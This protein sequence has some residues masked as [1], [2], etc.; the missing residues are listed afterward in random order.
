MNIIKSYDFFHYLRRL[1]FVEAIYLYGSR[2]KNSA[3]SSSDLD[4]AILCPKASVADWNKVN[5]II[6][7]ADTLLKID[8][9]RLDTL[10]DEMLK[11]EIEKD[12][13]VLFERKANNYS[14]YE[15]FLDLGEAIEKFEDIMNV[16]IKEFT[17]T[18]EAAIHIFEYSFESF[19]NCLKKIAVDEGLISPSPRS[20][21]Q[22]AFA[23]KLI[24]SEDSWLAMMSDRN[25]TS[26]TY[27]IAAVKAI[28]SN[29]EAYSHI[30][31]KTYDLL[32]EKYAL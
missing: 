29:L 3:N 6:Y 18:R 21:L 4:I 13:I 27:N 12:K 5:E 2:A 11:H 10:T 9:L 8:C 26:H 20:A 16:S 19:W 14:W 15:I 1:P 30:M 23:L 28:Y 24:E 7:N 32:R 17:Y 31:R 22:N 25:A